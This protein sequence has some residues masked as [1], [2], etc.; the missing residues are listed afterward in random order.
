MCNGQRGK[1]EQERESSDNDLDQF[2]P[3]EALAKVLG[4]DLRLVARLF[5]G[6]PAA[7][8]LDRGI[9]IALKHLIMD[10]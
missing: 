9:G 1:E 7:V 3:T 4:N 5:V 10:E 8:Q 2:V 6:F